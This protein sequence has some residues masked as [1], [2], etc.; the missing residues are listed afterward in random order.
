ITQNSPNL[1]KVGG[2]LLGLH[3]VLGFFKELNYSIK[4][5]LNLVGVRELL[6]VM[7]RYLSRILTQNH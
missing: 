4:N 1:V 2:V 7:D 3:I 6:F 5:S